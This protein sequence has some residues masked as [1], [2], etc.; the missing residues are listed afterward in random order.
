MSRETNLPAIPEVGRSADEIDRMLRAV[1]EIVEVGAGRRGAKEDRYVTLRELK[2]SQIVEVSKSGVIVG[3]GAAIA[4]QPVIVDGDNDLLPDNSPPDYGEG[5]TTPP[6][7]P[8]GLRN[9]S[10]PQ[11]NI[12]LYWNAP[13][14]GNHLLTEVEMF[15]L[16]EPVFGW[17][18]IGTPS[19]SQFLA[20]NLPRPSLDSTAGVYFKFRVRFKSRAGVY[21][22]YSAESSGALSID[23]LATL[24]QLV[25][26]VQANPL[27]ADLQAFIGVGPDNGE[28]FE[29][30]R[31]AGGLTRMTNRAGELYSVKIQQNHP[32]GLS[33]AAGFGLG[34]LVDDEGESTSLFAVSADKFA[35][36]GSTRWWGGTFTQN[37]GIP[38][39]AVLGGFNSLE[40]SNGPFRVG[41]R[42][43][44]SAFGRFLPLDALECEVTASSQYSMTVETIAPTGGTQP[45]FPALTAGTTP[46]DAL[47]FGHATNIPFVVDTQRGIVGIRGKLVVDGLVRA[48]EGE[49]DN[50][51][52]NSAFFNVARARIMAADVFVGERFVAGAILDANGEPIG[53][54]TYN[55]WIVEM[56]RPQPGMSPFRIYNPRNFNAGN[57]GSRL[58]EVTSG[59]TIDGRY[60]PG[61]LYVNGN[62]SI[63]GNGIFN[64]RDGG[65]VAMGA[66]SSD[67]WRYTF[68]C[69]TDSAYGRTAA[70]M[71][72]Y[73]VNG[74]VAHGGF[75]WIRKDGKAGFN[76]DLFLGQNA[77]A[78]PSASVNGPGATLTAEQPS[79]EF[80][81]NAGVAYPEALSASTFVLRGLKD[82]R[83]A[84]NLIIVSGMLASVTDASDG[85][86]KAF[87]L[88]AWLE[89][90]ATPGA[91]QTLLHTAIYDDVYQECFPFTIMGIANVNT[92]TYRVRLKV[93]RMATNER[94]MAIIQNWKVIALQ[95]GGTG[96]LAQLPSG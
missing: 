50:L 4:G 68:W 14:Y 43:I 8:T 40:F 44:F 75:F 52:A 31:A 78:L 57:P 93:T 48:T 92:N 88:E 90:A 36:M 73:T 23:P 81:A 30:L 51:S 56:S 10:V 32:S 42:I 54:D 16:A 29:T 89:P 3:G 39:R 13:N 21:G 55:D 94:E 62:L 45:A 96:G 60:V 22:P 85:R 71:E 33:V 63:G 65:A 86:D 82:G 91:N 87:K 24:N 67:N 34:F 46:Q 11:S 18:Q 35:I 64:L 53:L 7:Q 79:A 12:M 74:N 25:S 49:F 19:G 37:P 59:G 15:E 76:V 17:R 5:D 70:E 61:G 47:K 84:D 2:D 58:F 95:L 28:D 80:R 20:M 69:G 9:T 26:E 27:Y 6:P 83:P 1:K 66:L 77:L 38:H 41:D 72:G